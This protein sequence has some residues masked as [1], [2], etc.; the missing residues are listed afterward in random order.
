[1]GPVSPLRAKIRGGKLQDLIMKSD[2][3]VRLLQGQLDILNTQ[4]ASVETNLT[5]TLTEREQTVS[6]LE[7]VRSEVTGMDPCIIALE[8]KISVE[9]VAAARTRLETE[10]AAL[11]GRYNALVQDEQVKISKSQTLE[12]YIEKGKAWMNSLQNQAA[13]QRVQIN[14]VETDIETE[15]W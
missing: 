1:V 7:A 3:I 6:A 12:R 8:N 14:E 15:I 11:N 9:E 13:T 2:V 10:L 4:K 5:G